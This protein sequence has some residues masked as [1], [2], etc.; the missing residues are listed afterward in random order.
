MYKAVRNWHSLLTHHDHSK[1][2]LS[3]SKRSRN[4]HSNNLTNQYSKY[5]ST[6]DNLLSKPLNNSQEINLSFNTS[7][8]KFSA[9]PSNN[10]TIIPSE[11]YDSFLSSVKSYFKFSASP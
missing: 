1:N 7:Y 3:F 4:S 9:S 6:Y 5:A 11:V 10:Q 8:F 2:K